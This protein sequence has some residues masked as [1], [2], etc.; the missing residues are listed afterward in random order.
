MTHDVIATC[1]VCSNELAITRLHC[2]SC[3]TTLE[4]DFSVG[5][6][7]RLNRDQLALLESFLRS[8]GNLREMERELGIS[9][10]TVRA[11]VEA[12]VRALGFGARADAS[13]D[14]SEDDT[15]VAPL[16]R[17]RDSILERLARREISAEDAAMAIRDLGKESR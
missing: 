3:G 2:G 1:P 16:P 4:G 15:A 12:L 17:T 7:G 10:P 14:T 11:R 8:R 5:R 9:Y 6:F 13:P